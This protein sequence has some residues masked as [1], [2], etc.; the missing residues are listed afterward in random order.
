MIK[1]Y[2]NILIMNKIFTDPAIKIKIS[3]VKLIKN[4]HKKFFFN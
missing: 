1:Y 2:N 4:K 3:G